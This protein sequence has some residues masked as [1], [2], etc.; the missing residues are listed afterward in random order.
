[1]TQ[2]EKIAKELLSIAKELSAVGKEQKCYDLLFNIDMPLDAIA[3][4]LAVLKKKAIDNRGQMIR[5]ER[6]FQ[7]GAI[8]AP[9][10]LGM[11]K[12]DFKNLHTDIT[13]M[14]KVIDRVC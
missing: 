5:L 2:D 1:M 12:R 14:L 4:N 8:E 11:L 13:N 6:Q 9:K 7:S 3:K 10:L